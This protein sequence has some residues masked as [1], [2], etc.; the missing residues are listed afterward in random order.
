MQE[1]E[2]DDRGADVHCHCHEGGRDGRPGVLAGVEDRGQKRDHHM[3]DQARKEDQVDRDHR[4]GRG[5]VE[6]AVLVEQGDG[7][8]RERHH[9]TGDRHDDEEEE[10][11]RLVDEAPESVV[12]AQ[13]EGLRERRQQHYPQ[14]NTDQADWDLER[15]EG[16]VEGGD[17]AVRKG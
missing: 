7:R 14:R 1:R 12:L 6:L 9:Q 4:C 16:Q 3:S 15:D 8:C 11:Q 2:E 13:G 5:C 10:S 17:I